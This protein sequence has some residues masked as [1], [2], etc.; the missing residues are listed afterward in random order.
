MHFSIKG[1]WNYNI[2]LHHIFIFNV[3]LCKS[4]ISLLI[5]LYKTTQTNTY[6]LNISVLL[7]M[8]IL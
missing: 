7:C 5:V 6:Y 3:I 1:R 4:S 2:V 8:I